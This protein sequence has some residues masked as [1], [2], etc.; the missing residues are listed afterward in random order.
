VL[1]LHGK[2]FSGA[3]WEPTIRQLLRKGFRVIAPEA[4]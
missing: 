3:Y 2:N 1:L 4:R